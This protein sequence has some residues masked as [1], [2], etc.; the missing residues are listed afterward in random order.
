MTI[1]KTVKVVQR[2]LQRYARNGWR[3]VVLELRGELHPYVKSNPA[4]FDLLA[5]G[6][7]QI[8]EFQGGETAEMITESL[9][10]GTSDA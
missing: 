3:V 6:A 1:Q 10:M 5:K 2:L 9:E 7:R 8:A 4:V